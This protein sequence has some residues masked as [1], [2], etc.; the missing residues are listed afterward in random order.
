MQSA[1]TPLEGPEVHTASYNDAQISCTDLDREPIG[2]IV[3]ADIVLRNLSLHP[4]GC[5][6]QC[7]W[8][9][10]SF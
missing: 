4:I 5:L 8:K 10:S 2:S 1:A 7:G 9:Q 6:R 3:S